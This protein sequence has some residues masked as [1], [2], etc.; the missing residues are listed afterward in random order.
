[1]KY[2]I[3]INLTHS[4]A[5]SRP[6]HVYLYNTYIYLCCAIPWIRSLRSSTCDL[7]SYRPVTKVSDAKRDSAKEKREKRFQLSGL[8][9]ELIRAKLLR[10]ECTM[11]GGVMVPKISIP[12]TKAFIYLFWILVCRSAR[13]YL[14]FCVKL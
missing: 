3:N 6:T 13:A 2:N 5:A 8:R 1:M 11:G 7:I 12:I 10:N 9:I 4:K 14:A